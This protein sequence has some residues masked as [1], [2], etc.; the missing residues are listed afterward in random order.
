MLVTGNRPYY[1]FS[2]FNNSKLN[3][4]INCKGVSI[5]F[6]VF[7]EKSLNLSY[8]YINALIHIRRIILVLYLALFIWYFDTWYVLSLDMSQFILDRKIV[9]LAGDCTNVFRNRILEFA[10]ARINYFFPLLV[11][12]RSLF[13]L[14]IN[15]DN[16]VSVWRLCR[17]SQTPDLIM[18]SIY[19]IWKIKSTN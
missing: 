17:P 13:I 18:S 12:I 11:D 9:F 1:K 5:F 7:P 8:C 3:N 4:I 6:G 2:Y 10:R 16:L 19:I 15:L 14:R